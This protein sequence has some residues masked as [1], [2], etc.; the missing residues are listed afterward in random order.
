[1]QNNNNG[2][3]HDVVGVYGGANVPPGT[4]DYVDAYHLGAELARA[5][6]AVMTGGY[7]GTMEA[8]SHGAA[9]ADGHVIGV[10][11][12]LFNE[13]GLM[14]NPFLTEE[15]HLPTLAA[16]LNYLIVK[17]DAYVFLKGGTGTLSELALAWSLMQVA[18]V[19]PRPMVLVGPMWRQ[20]VTHF[21]AVSTVAPRDLAL[22]TLV[23]SVRDV[24]PTLQAWWASPPHIQLRLGDVLKTPPP[25]DR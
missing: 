4:P 17:P 19:P 10:T 6:Y 24:L 5:G 9:Q 7:S 18:E 1:M 25:E 2:D 22:M 21:A 12:A 14:P 8:I 20:F 23:D 15:I 16:R 11:V 13:R 3:Q